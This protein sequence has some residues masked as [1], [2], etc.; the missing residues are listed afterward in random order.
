MTNFYQH[1]LWKTTVLPRLDGSLVIPDHDWSLRSDDG[2]IIA[3]VF[4]SNTHSTSS[5]WYWTVILGNDEHPLE[6]GS[7]YETS[8]SKAL[9]AAENRLEEVEK[10]IFAPIEDIAHCQDHNTT[11]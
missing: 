2:M 7:G 4:K 3:R 6:I 10:L 5:A 8:R 9:E 11:A 1:L